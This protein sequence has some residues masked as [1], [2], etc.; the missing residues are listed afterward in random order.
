MLGNELMIA[1]VYKQNAEGRYVYLPEEMMLVRMKSV[2]RY[3]TKILPK[4][5]HY[6]D[7]ALE[8]LVFFI[9]SGKA[10]PF[11]SAAD[12]TEQ[13]SNVPLSLLGY[14]GASYELYSDDGISQN[15]R[16]SLRVVCKK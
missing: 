16:D 1:P 8:E 4:G 14:T 13:L 7:A 5:H 2:D 10:I 11:G 6:V 12:N 9:R 3:E 15:P